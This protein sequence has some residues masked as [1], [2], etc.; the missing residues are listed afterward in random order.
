MFEVVRSNVQQVYDPVVE[1]VCTKLQPMRQ[2]DG[3]LEL[4]DVAA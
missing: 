1:R 3:K 2:K 4:S